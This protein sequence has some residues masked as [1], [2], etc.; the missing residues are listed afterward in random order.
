MQSAYKMV[1]ENK[2]K[3]EEALLRNIDDSFRKI[4]ILGEPMPIIR[5][6]FAMSSIFFTFALPV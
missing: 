2:I 3:Q 1:D 6:V 4:I 5:T